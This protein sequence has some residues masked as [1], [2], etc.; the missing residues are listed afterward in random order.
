MKIS[1]GER[2]SL[3][4]LLIEQRAALKE[5]LYR[6][7]G[8]RSIISQKDPDNL[9][10]LNRASEAI[11]KLSYDISLASSVI[12]ALENNDNLYSERSET[13]VCQGCCSK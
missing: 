13:I 10:G 2:D 3:I 9:A 7:H 6:E 5:K 4:N 8:I 1:K 11:D 12:H